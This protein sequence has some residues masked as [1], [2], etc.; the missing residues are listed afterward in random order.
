MT[1][2]ND[3]EIALAGEYVL[4]LLSPA[5]Q[6][7]ASAKMASDAAFAAEVDAWRRRLEPMLDGGDETP[8]AY[9]WDRIESALP[10][11]SGQNLGNRPL[12]IWQGLTAASAAL[13]AYF[14]FLAWQPPT[15]VAPPPADTM[16]AAMAGENG[17]NAVTARYDADSGL[18]L[19]TPV[20]LDT[21]ALYPELWVVPSDG[22]PR[23]L[24][25][26]ARAR[27]TQV[28]VRADLR[29]YLSQ[30]ALLAITP[31]P[32]GGAPNG[33]ATG[34]IIASGKIQII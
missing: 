14:G 32:A 16:I 10:A 29:Q 15:A 22:Q 6:A 5:E 24:G 33:K 12:R 11:S 26:M 25:I 19:I 9:I 1:P 18:L 30:G 21:G 20:A 28:T 31:E 13:A 23:S 2:L 7:A 4:G 27:P 17:T 34:P 8:P 3:E